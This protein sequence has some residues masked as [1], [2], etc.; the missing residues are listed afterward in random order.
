M[1][2]CLRT[3]YAMP[4]DTAFLSS[5]CCLA[6]AHQRRT[7]Y[8]APYDALFFLV[9]FLPRAAL[10]FAKLDIHYIQNT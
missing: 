3:E 6:E 4:C 7:D 10:L 5:R 8:E 9:R 1:A 2:F